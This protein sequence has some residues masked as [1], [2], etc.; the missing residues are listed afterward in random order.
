M[1]ATPNLI[2]LSACIIAWCA[3]VATGAITVT[4]YKWYG[5]REDCLIGLTISF[6]L[7]TTLVFAALSFFGAISAIRTLGASDPA[8]S[9]QRQAD[10]RRKSY[11]LFQGKS[12]DSIEIVKTMLAAAILVALNVQMII[13]VFKPDCS[14]LDSWKQTGRISTSLFALE[15]GPDRKYIITAL[16]LTIYVFIFTGGFGLV[17]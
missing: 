8:G 15:R 14:F 17:A 10:H 2:K 3:C 7:L 16:L 9:S 12:M 13:F 6:V 11:K 1:E 4:F 5:V